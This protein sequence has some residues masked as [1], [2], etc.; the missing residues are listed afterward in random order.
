MDTNTVIVSRSMEL[1]EVVFQKLEELL[2]NLD[3]HF[4]IQILDLAKKMQNLKIDFSI[5]KSVLEVDSIIRNPNKDFMNFLLYH[6]FK[7]LFS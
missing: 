7:D 3:S 6:I 1:E 5:K 4:E 2:G